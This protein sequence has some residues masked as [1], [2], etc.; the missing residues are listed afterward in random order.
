MRDNSKM[1]RAMCGNSVA[2]HYLD[3][4]LND[5]DLGLDDPGLNAPL[6]E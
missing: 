4:G 5:P 3:L 6:V 2:A 1:T